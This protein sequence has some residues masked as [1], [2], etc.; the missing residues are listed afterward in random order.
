[1]WTVLK[2]LGAG[3]YSLKVTFWLFGLLGM[4]FF[5]IATHM[6]HSGALRA[7]CP[8]GRLCSRSVILY[9]LGNVPVLM[10]RSGYLSIFV[11]HLL[12][13]AC[14]AGYFIV[15]IRGL[16]K[17][18]DAYEGSKALPVSAKIVIICLGLL[19]LKAII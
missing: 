16:W 14:F 7:I 19:S 8:H 1:M 4:L 2:K 6:T 3:E 13:A 18:S 12:M 11:P 15:L 17:C 5:T 10:T 9:I